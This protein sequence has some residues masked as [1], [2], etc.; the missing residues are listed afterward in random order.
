MIPLVL[1]ED[2]N[3][4][5]AVGLRQPS[6]T[7]Y[8]KLVAHTGVT[9]LVPTGAKHVLFSSSAN[10]FAQYVSSAL[11]S[12]VY[13]ASNSQASGVSRAGTTIELNPMLRSLAGVTGIGVI[14]PTAGDMTLS[15]FG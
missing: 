5:S 15:W 13:A 10:F 1:S 7:D 8:I 11:T 3:G 9:L 2:N 6:F 4:N 12:A 14:A